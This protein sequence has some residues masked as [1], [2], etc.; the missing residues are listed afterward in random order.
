MGLQDNQLPTPRRVESMKNWIPKFVKNI[1]QN[2]VLINV[3]ANS[4]NGIGRDKVIY[5]KLY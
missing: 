4:G 2:I 1:L 5:L 3:A